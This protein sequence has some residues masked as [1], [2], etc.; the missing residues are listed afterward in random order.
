MVFSNHFG[1]NP[2]T[3]QKKNTLA[4]RKRKRLPSSQESPC[5]SFF[6]FGTVGAITQ[7]QHQ[8]RSLSFL[9]C[10]FLI[11][12]PSAN[13]RVEGF[14]C[15]LHPTAERFVI[16]VGEG[17]DA[18]TPDTGPALLNGWTPRGREIFTEAQQPNSKVPGSVSKGRSRRFFR[19]NSW[20]RLEGTHEP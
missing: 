4:Q 3:K 8:S 18:M 13:A 1:F 6:C 14:A 19:Q 5:F 2:Q 20:R 16:P 10:G 9:R 7:S 15:S 12:S 17:C 11:P